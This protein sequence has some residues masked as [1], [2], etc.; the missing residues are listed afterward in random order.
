M[1]RSIVLVMLVI[2]SLLGSAVSPALAQDMPDFK[3]LIT[4]DQ[5][6]AHVRAL[7]VDIGARVAGT[8]AEAQAADYIA[9]AFESWGY[10]VEIQEFDFS[11]DEANADAVPRVSRNVIATRAGDDQMIVVGAHMDSVSVGTGAGDNASGVAA[12][13]GAA[14]ALADVET[15]YTLVFVAFGAEE[16]GLVGSHE[17]VNSLSDNIAN[18]IAMINLDSVGVG[19]QLNVYAGALVT[20]PEN[21]NHPPQFE[22][23]PTWVRDTALGLAAEMGLP[24]STTPD[25]SWGGFI[26]D[27]SDHYAF[28]EAGVP[29]AYFEAF[30]WQGADDPWWGIETPQGEVMHTEKD[31]IDAVVPEKVEMAA[32][33]LAA[34][35]YEIASGQVTGG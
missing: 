25:S 35:A 15:V 22:G 5:V 14:E 10:A 27:W 2:M 4:A 3:T 7:S 8:E 31:T 28:V 19:S 20:S 33:L 9:S 34:T 23:G 18:V 12:M 30:G 11:N 21:G 16:V 24:F 17:Y 32:E 1:R 29:I 6:M 13:L 26:G